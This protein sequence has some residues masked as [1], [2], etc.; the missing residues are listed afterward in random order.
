MDTFEQKE[1]NKIRPIK[2]TWYD[3]LINYISELIRKS[4][5]GFNDEG[6]SLFK[7]NT[8]KQ[9]VFRRGKKLSKSKTQNKINRIRNPFI[10]KRKKG[11]KKVII[12][13]FND[14]IVRD[15]YTL[16]EIEKRKK[17]R[18]RLKKIND[19]SI[20]DKIIRDIRTVLNSKN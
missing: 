16:F 20:K 10:L 11:K 7:T 6:I 8:P 19:R 1:M 2:D 13:I 12:R 9:T 15:I 17:E 18:K 3:W 4:A 14:R 5:S